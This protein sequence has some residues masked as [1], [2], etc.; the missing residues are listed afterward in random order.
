MQSSKGRNYYIQKS[1]KSAQLPFLLKFSFSKEDN[2]KTDY[3][4]TCGLLEIT[5]YFIVTVN[6][7]LMNISDL[8]DD[9]T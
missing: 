1:N 3:F 8:Y 5:Q 9:G 4:T 6:E 7:Y 2:L